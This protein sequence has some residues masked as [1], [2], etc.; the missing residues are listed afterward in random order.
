VID[1]VVVVGAFDGG[2]VVEEAVGSTGGA[3]LD[4]SERADTIPKMSTT[5]SIEPRPKIALTKWKPSLRS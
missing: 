1:L 5:I 2:D 4:P 3:L